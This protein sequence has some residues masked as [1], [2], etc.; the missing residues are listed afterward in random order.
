[1]S[2]SQPAQRR[3]RNRMRVEPIEQILTKAAGLDA[4]EQ[5][6]ARRRDQPDIGP[7]QAPASAGATLAILQRAQEP[8][9]RPRRQS[10]DFV[11]IE[12]AR[13]APRSACRAA[14]TAAANVAVAEQDAFDTLG[15]ASRRTA[16]VTK[17]RPRRSDAATIP[18]CK[19]PFADAGL[20]FQQNRS[21][22]LGGAFAKPHGV[23]QHPLLAP[24]IS[25]NVHRARPRAAPRTRA[26]STS[27]ADRRNAFLIEAC[28]RSAPSGFMTKLTAA[29]P[30]QRAT[31]RPD[32]L[33][34]LHDRP[35]LSRSGSRP[36]TGAAR[37]SRRGS[38]MTRSRI[39]RSTGGSCDAARRSSARRAA[40]RCLR[41]VAEAIAQG[42]RAA[43]AAPDRRR[44]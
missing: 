4:F 16:S 32:F 21:R 36:A 34:R 18:A 12:R 5:I 31:A 8:S 15:G 3:D 35:G 11:E 14:R 40:S 37:P 41:G 19:N 10:A 1:M 29:G 26:I 20:P 6:F 33:G 44:Q 42:S 38:G 43:A 30:P 22:R 39:I 13:P 28:S 9:L 2:S 25:E 7:R 24:A 23:L 27:R 17:G